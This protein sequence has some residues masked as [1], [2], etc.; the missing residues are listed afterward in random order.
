MVVRES[1]EDEDAKLPESTFTVSVLMGDASL[2]TV[3]ISSVRPT[4]DESE[5][6]R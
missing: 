3:M 2:V 6:S 1:S 5:C 4:V